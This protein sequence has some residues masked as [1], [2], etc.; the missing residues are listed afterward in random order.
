MKGQGREQTPFV[1]LAPTI[2]Q[3][4]VKGNHLNRKW[5]N[6]VMIR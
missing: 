6:D 1:L 4:K 5:T 2:E 3:T